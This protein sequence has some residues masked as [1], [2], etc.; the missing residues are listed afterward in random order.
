MSDHTETIDMYLAAWNET[1]AARRAELIERAW[2]PDGSYRDPMLD[3][4]GHAAIERMILGVHEQFPGQ[5]FRRTTGI[6]AHHDVCRFGWE[7]AAADDSVT[8]AVIDVATLDRVGRLARV[9]GFFGD[10]TD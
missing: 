4:D 7:L 10:L 3:A 1:D 9:A 2:A 8:V 5:R 6:D